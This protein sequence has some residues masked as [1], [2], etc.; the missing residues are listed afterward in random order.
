MTWKDILK[1]YEGTIVEGDGNGLYLEVDT[2]NRY[3]LSMDPRDDLTAANHEAL[4]VKSR[5]LF[6]DYIG[7][8]IK[9]RGYLE[10]D[11][12]FAATIVDEN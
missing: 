3:A 5:L 7:M 10:G 9:I 1:I 8:D 6:A 2:E 11:T 4:W 12:I